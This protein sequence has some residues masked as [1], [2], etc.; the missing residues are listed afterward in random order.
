VEACDGHVASCSKLA[1]PSTAP[2]RVS[3]L[4]RSTDL[5]TSL[6]CAPVRPHTCAGSS[7]A[8]AQEKSLKVIMHSDL[9]ALDPVWSGADIVGNHGYLV[10]DTLF[11]LDAN[12]QIQPQI[13]RRC[14]AH[15]LAP[16]AKR[17]LASRSTCRLWIGKAW[18]TD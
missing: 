9:K 14:C 6:A 16:V 8:D 4:N 12:F 7:P 3:E 5:A 17:L 13:I 18:S 1:Q 2:P 11:A 15:Q 10:Y